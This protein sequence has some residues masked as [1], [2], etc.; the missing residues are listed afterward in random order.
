MNFNGLTH[1]K[2]R[3]DYSGGTAQQDRMIAHK[4][5]TLDKAT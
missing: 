4:R 1:M 3:L 5:K 2:T